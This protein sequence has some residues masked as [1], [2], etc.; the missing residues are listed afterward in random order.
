MLGQLRKDLLLRLDPS[1]KNR[2]NQSRRLQNLILVLLHLRLYV[3]SVSY[4]NRNR[5]KKS[6]SEKKR[7][8]G[9]VD[10]EDSLEGGIGKSYL[11]TSLRQP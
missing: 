1:L 5:R 11:H 4:L 3:V 2:R 8:E 6:R 7:E 10:W 9:R